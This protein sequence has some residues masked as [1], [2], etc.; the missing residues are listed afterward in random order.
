ML[1]AI[2]GVWKNLWHRGA[3]K[4]QLMVEF[5]LILPFLLVLIIGSI[6]FGFLF[7]D[8][9][10]LNNVARS[11][12]REASLQEGTDFSDIRTRALQQSLPV[13]GVFNWGAS[14]TASQFSIEDQPIESSSTGTGTTTASTKSNIVVKIQLPLDPTY[15]FYSLLNHLLGQGSNPQFTT[16][17]QYVML[18]EAG[19]S[20]SSST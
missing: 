13:K 14:V 3:Q 2:Q 19:N 11:V 5:A 20:S 7:A 15:S 1:C 18:H 10:A 9:V 6:N 4:A 16:N 12:A 17:I 8:Y